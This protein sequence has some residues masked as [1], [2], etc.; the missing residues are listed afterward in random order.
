[1]NKPDWARCWIQWLVVET[2]VVIYDSMETYGTLI[3]ECAAGERAHAT[4]AA[5]WWSPSMGEVRSSWAWVS[6]YGRFAQRSSA[7]YPSQTTLD[8]H[9]KIIILH[10]GRT[11]S[12]S[13]CSLARHSTSVHLPALL[14]LGRLPDL[15]I[16]G[17]S[18]GGR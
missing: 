11:I 15:E 13:F 6:I 10:L 18:H 9:S 12:T 14:K 8:P 16:T 7:K 1:M 17:E 4:E 2:K 3:P 5:Y